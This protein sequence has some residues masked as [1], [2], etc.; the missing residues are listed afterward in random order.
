MKQLNEIIWLNTLY[1]AILTVV[2]LA[3]ENFQLYFLLCV[4]FKTDWALYQHPPWGDLY[5]ISTLTSSYAAYCFL[6]PLLIQMTQIWA[7][8]VKVTI[9]RLFTVPKFPHVV[10]KENRKKAHTILDLMQIVSKV[11]LKCGCP[12]SDVLSYLCCNKNKKI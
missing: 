12:I 11:C 1:P 6:F 7:I 4:T 3:A 9:Y 2:S 5:H 8:S 10:M